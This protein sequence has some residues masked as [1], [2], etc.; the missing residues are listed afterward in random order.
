VAQI[1]R[2]ASPRSKQS[3]ADT[4]RVASAARSIGRFI[5]ELA[6]EGIAATLAAG[7]AALILIVVE[8]L[9]YA[10]LIFSGPLSPFVNIGIGITL[11]TAV[12]I[13]LMTTAFGSYPGMIAFSQSKVAAVTSFMAASLASAAAAS[14]PAE[15]VALTV[16]AAIFVS[17]IIT[18]AALAGLGA[19]KLGALVRFIPYPV[20]CGFLA[21]VGWLLCLGAFKTLTGFALTPTSLP[22]LIQLGVIE[23]WAPG[24]AFAVAALVLM[25]HIKHY[26][27]MPLLILAALCCF[28]LALLWSGIPVAEARHDGWLVHTG[29][30][31]NL[32]HNLTF[33]AATEA[34][35]G[36]IAQ[37]AGAVAT[38]VI[39]SAVA[40][41][42]NSS[43]VELAAGRDIDLNRELK[44]AGI[45]NILSGLCGGMVGF[46]SVNISKFVLSIGVRGRLV[47]LI[48][49]FGCFAI[50]AGGA[51]I[52]EFVPQL[53]IGGLLLYIGLEFLYEWLYLP[54][55]EFHVG[56]L[57][58][59]VII[60]AIVSLVGLIEGIIVGIVSAIII[61]TVKYSGLDVVKLDTSIAEF[62]STMQRPDAEV[63]L[64]EQRGHRAQILQLRDFVFFGSADRL[65]TRVRARMLGD[66][67][68]GT[69]YIIL[70]FRQVT[71]IDLSAII[72]FM[73]LGQLAH[74]AD[75]TVIL[76]Q[77]PRPVLDQMRKGGLFARNEAVWKLF[78]S[79]D[80]GVEWC[81]DRLLGEEGKLAERPVLL[82]R[83][84]QD[85]GFSAEDAAEFGTYVSRSRYVTGE[86]L[87]R[88]GEVSDALCFVEDGVVAVQLNFENGSQFRVAKLGA[89]SFVGEMGF[90]LQTLRTADVIVEEDAT[91]CSLSRSSADSLRRT[92][93]QLAAQFHEV[94]IHILANRLVLTD[95]LLRSLLH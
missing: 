87:I 68:V 66:R 44:V 63:A 34:D 72:S 58:I 4:F 7:L 23:H 28:Y 71:G 90:Y 92:A 8:S 78:P 54:A 29:S 75:V 62:R 59:V 57:S 9:S 13:G 89:G 41:L 93:P 53:L 60:L 83:F 76:T 55:R 40:L 84:L 24:A 91:I 20:I 65:L 36:L 69:R 51:K 85:K 1:Q 42:L 49:A 10:A 86:K 70:D 3:W 64:L 94:L 35:F 56:D 14:M 52:V 77:V 15:Q 18:G 25:H 16:A 5:G 46:S 43:A 67:D 45:G 79:L 17:T 48:G 37:Q 95:R 31:G 11:I 38:I 30:T 26:M 50:L 2:A 82:P 47:G 12:V 19:F 88:Q 81:E 22:T 80:L 6:P 39:V 61:F 73:R 27:V 74:A 32:F 21:S 33:K